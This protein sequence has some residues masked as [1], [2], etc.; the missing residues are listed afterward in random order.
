MADGNDAGEQPNNTLL[1]DLVQGMGRIEGQNQ[2]ILQ[3]QS[4]AADG[5]KEQ[6]RALD[7][8]RRDARDL[9]F[10]VAEIDTRVSRISAM[11]PDFT[12]MK[13][14]R[15]QAALAVVY[16]TAA[17]TG[18]FNLIWYGLTHASDIKTALREFLR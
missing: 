12:K 1:L 14:F 16:V 7:E 8:L 10:T 9:K 3:E 5:R 2:L 18:A 11:E 4:R 17:V 6:Y 15:A 13:A